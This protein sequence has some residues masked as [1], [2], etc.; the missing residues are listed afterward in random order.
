MPVFD[1]QALLVLPLHIYCRIPQVGMYRSMSI[2]LKRRVPALRFGPKS[3]HFRFAFS[4][5][6][7]YYRHGL[8]V[9]IFT[10]PRE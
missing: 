3:H 9:N 7:V 6:D 1:F 10:E 4:N 8:F 5:I 2:F